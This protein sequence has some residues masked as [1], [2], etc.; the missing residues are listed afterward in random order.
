MR[1]QLMEWAGLALIAG[2]LG[3]GV[4]IALGVGAVGAYLFG[5][6]VLREIVEGRDGDEEKRG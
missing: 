3:W 6:A 1:N 2:A 5:A 4:D